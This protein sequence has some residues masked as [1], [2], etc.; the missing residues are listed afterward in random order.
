VGASFWGQVYL[1]RDRMDDDSSQTLS[2]VGFDVNRNLNTKRHGA[3]LGVDYGFGFGRIGLTGGYARAKANDRD[4]GD[5]GMKA[6]GYNVGVYGQFGGRTGF[7]GEVFAKHDRYN[8]DFTSG[9]FDGI[10][11]DVRATGFDGALGFRFPLG[12]LATLDANAGASYVRTKFDDVDAFG[13]GYDLDTVKSVRGRAGLRAAFGGSFSPYV[14]AT[15]Y[16]EFRGDGR[17]ALFDGANSFGL[18]NE[19]RATWFRL[20]GG[21]MPNPTGLMLAAWADLG[22]KKGVG[23]RL[24]FRFGGAA[25]AAEPLIEVAPVIAPPPPPP[26][27][28]T[29]TCPDG[30]VI[31]A[32][33]ACPVAP[34]PPPPPPA[35][36]ERG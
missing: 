16:R 26:A 6:D 3:Q 1:S 20:E 21:V 35:A 15:V 11:T 25:R 14:D 23:A 10:D 34:P 17:V 18:R 30:S 36:P 8:L 9:A 5:L 33:D 27:P 28:A 32:T 2:G 22:D 31:L 24:G 12:S 7:H 29:Q 4:A 13:F 19:G